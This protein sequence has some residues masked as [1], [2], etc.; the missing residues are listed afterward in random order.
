MKTMKAVYSYFFPEVRPLLHEVESK[1]P[2][3]MFLVTTPLEKVRKK[4]SSLFNP[5]LDIPGNNGN[6]DLDA[7]H[8]PIIERI[9]KEYSEIIPALGE[10][11]YVYPTPGSSEGIHKILTQL[12]TKG[13]EEINVLRGE[14]EGYTAYGED[15][16][17]RVNNVDINEDVKPGYW[18]IS[19]PSARDGNIIPNEFINQLCNKGHKIIMDLAYASSTRSYKFDISHKNI[20][21]ALLSLSKPYGVFRFRIGFTLSREEIPSLYGNKWFKDPV[22]LLQGLKI[23]EEL[24]VRTLFNKYR[25]TQEKII[26]GINKEFGLTIK[27]SDALLLGY[28][29]QEDAKQLSPEKQEMIEPFKRG[30]VYRFCLTPYYEQNEGDKNGHKKQ[31]T[32]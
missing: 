11:Q 18:C 15:L 27:P 17:M 32:E 2:D 30:E 14:Y 21:A 3:E 19:N 9:I 22:R 5:P 24:G 29:S 23:V 31:T 16:G 13:V 6:I 12:R 8:E 1:I 20:T 7:I 26:S 4:I 28:M 25:P 10:F